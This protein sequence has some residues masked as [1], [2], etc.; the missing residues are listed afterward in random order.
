VYAD[1]LVTDSYLLRNGCTPARRELPLR[2]GGLNR[3]R[4]KRSGEVGGGSL[5][6]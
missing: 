2:V 1:S 6:P 5:H 4:G 3:S